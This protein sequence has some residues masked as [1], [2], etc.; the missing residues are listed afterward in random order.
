M[1]ICAFRSLRPRI[2]WGL[3]LSLL[4]LPTSP[5]AVQA[6]S[7]TEA[8]TPDCA[9][10]GL[11]S[12]PV[13]VRLTRTEELV[14]AT[15]HAPPGNLPASGCRVPLEFHIPADARPARTVW[16]D[17]ETR[18]VRL[19]GTPDPA[20]PDPL[21]L[22]LWIRPDGNL[23]YEVREAGVKATHA[24]LD[25]AVAWG[26][27]AAA[28]DL[29][30]L[31]ILGAALGLEPSPQELGARLDDRG[32][33]TELD[34]H[35]DH[36]DGYWKGYGISAFLVPPFEFSKEGIH[37]PGVRTTWQLPSELGQLS[38]LRELR[39]GGPLLTGTIPPELGQ[40]TELELLTLAGSRLSGAVPPELGQLIQLGKLELHNNLLTAL[41]PELGQL[42]Q[43]KILYLSGNQ[44]TDLPPELGQLSHLYWL[45]LAGNQL[46]SLPNEIGRL[47]RLTELGL[48]GNQLTTLPSEFGQLTG[49]VTLDLQ[50]N[51]LS[52]LP[53]LA[54]LA[55]L[56]YLDL[57]GN[58]L[59]APPPG[60]PA[61]HWLMALDLSDNQIAKL[62]PGSISQPIE[63]ST[64][65]SP[66]FQAMRQ[67][68]REEGDNQLTPLPPGLSLFQAMRQWFREEG[69][70]ANSFLQKLDLSGN[71]LTEW[72]SDLSQLQ[73]E[74]LDLSDNQLTA[75]PSEFG[76]M[77]PSVF[78]DGSSR[79]ASFSLKLNLSGNQLTEWPD[80]LLPLDQL[81]E[82]N[83]SGN[84]LTELSKDLF[85]M[86]RLSRLT[87]L[88]L[89]DNQLTALPDTLF[90]M[91]RL[92]TLN[93]SGNRFATVPPAI[94]DLT[95]L[96]TLG[97]GDNQLTTLPPEL[98]QLRQLVSL[99][100][101][102]N[103]L[104]ALPPE[105]K[106][107]LI[108]RH[109]NLSANQLKN[110]PAGLDALPHL[111]SL[112][113]SGNQLTGLSD[114][115]VDLEQVA[116]LPRR[117]RQ[118]NLSDNQLTAVPPVVTQFRLEV[119]NLSRNQLTDLPPDLDQQKILKHLDLSHNQFSDIPPVLSRLRPLLF[120]DLR[121]NPLTACPLPLRW[122]ID[123]Y[124]Y[125]P[126]DKRYVDFNHWYLSSPT[127]TE[128]PDLSF[129]ELCPE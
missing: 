98:G 59:T 102:G 26:T 104:T 45:G 57:S 106:R 117:L 62:P 35:A 53:S 30:V 14:Q 9:R 5:S 52:E 17:V 7:T 128:H 77:R 42:I 74:T 76:Q 60:L 66:L 119:L 125:S 27:T 91:D 100:L 47:F 115:A 118:L 67:W 86:V 56:N 124:I 37:P 49:L 121:G 107:S 39:L 88:D 41:P 79:G 101:S 48:A 78:Y 12:R 83:L 82:L 61:L 20:R 68:F 16:R 36:P 85:R 33:V 2:P 63:S 114:P 116:Q 123:R 97:L 105:L 126:P 94:G 21:P 65:G 81:T 23:E 28:N 72:P 122:R 71:Q 40:L 8:T 90:Q 109:L 3:L 32:R 73:L 69:I 51:Q 50:D 54:G 24:A 70:E 10:T 31:D 89:G 95:A 113:L 92:R 111:D 44:L 129:L 6:A 96:V 43:L 55:A 38:Q 84:Q 19:D 127:S 120:L 11:A 29:A 1:W 80:A 13:A 99:D 103:R 87:H 58:R 93:L 110:L 75:L 25:L 108:L 34:W 4:L 15:L 64:Q 22:R 18:A 46:A 112:D